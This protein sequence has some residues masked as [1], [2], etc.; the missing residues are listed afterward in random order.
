MFFINVLIAGLLSFIYFDFKAAGWLDKVIQVFIFTQAIGISIYFFVYYSEVL[1]VRSLWKRS[2]GLTSVFI[3]GGCSGTL[4]ALGINYLI[5]DERP[6]RLS[7]LFVDNT[8]LALLFGAVV[9][10][11]FVLRGR[12]EHAIA[13]LA[14]KEVNE[15]RLLRL[16]TKAELEALRAKINPHFLFNALNSI[17]S[18][19]PVDPQRAEEI[20]QRLSHLFRYTLDA[21][22]RETVQLSDELSLIREYLEIEKVR[23]G[24]RLSYEIIADSELAN[25]PLPGLLLQPLVENSVKHGFASS[26]DGGQITIRCHRENDKCRIEIFDTGKGFEQA[27]RGEGF[28]LSSVRER[29]ALRY[30]KD[31]D[32]QLTHQNGVQIVIRLPLSQT[33]ADGDAS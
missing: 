16:K 28:G 27:Q 2:A 9:T 18:L 19:I 21:S 1:S 22:N 32:F 3:L 4:V 5:Y 10:S 24:E 26:K 15:Q 25:L 23:L 11:Y 7:K 17:A 8:L 20:V 12:F 29:L 6:A 33:G 30:G 13:Q 14:E 31:F